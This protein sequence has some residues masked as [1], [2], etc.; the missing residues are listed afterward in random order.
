[1]KFLEILGT[2]TSILGFLL[3]LIAVIKQK[4]KVL[5]LLICIMT[6]ACAVTFYHY[7]I[8]ADEKIQEVQRRDDAKKKALE[9]L[10]SVPTIIYRYETGKNKAITYQV[11]L[12]LE[13]YRDL[14][15]ET[16]EIYKEDVLSKMRKAEKETSEYNKGELLKECAE[17]SK[18]LI[19]FL[20]Y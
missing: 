1:M 18:Q 3:S 11:L 17:T 15:P 12:Y 14:F 9:L 2:I 7:R 8:L 19:L 13:K 5:A 20:S 10:E 6:I 16:A 4:E